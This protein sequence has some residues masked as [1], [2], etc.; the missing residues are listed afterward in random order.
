MRYF[1]FIM[2]CIFWHSALAQNRLMGSVVEVFVPNPPVSGGGLL[3]GAMIAGP[4]LPNTPLA[5]DALNLAIPG[6]DRP[7]SGCLYATSRDGRYSA[8]SVD[9]AVAP[10]SADIIPLE[11]EGFGGVADDQTFP[12][13]PKAAFAA[14][15]RLGGPCSGPDIAPIYPIT[16]R[17]EPHRSLHLALNV[18]GAAIRAV[19]L[20]VDGRTIEG[21]CADDPTQ[22]SVS[23]DQLCTI[24]LPD[25]ASGCGTLTVSYRPPGVFRPTTSEYDISVAIPPSPGCLN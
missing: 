1:M 9:L 17:D 25:Q 7:L 18:G 2:F 19:R 5:F 23:F 22:Q 20:H 11:M 15:V 10:G 21:A 24:D 13:Y 3:A 16:W 4:S 12:R 8:E 14:I 6:S